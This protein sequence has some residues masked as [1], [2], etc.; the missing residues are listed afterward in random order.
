MDFMAK[1]LLKDTGNAQSLFSMSSSNADGKAGHQMFVKDPQILD[2][3]LDAVRVALTDEAKATLRWLHQFLL[4]SLTYNC[5]EVFHDS[6]HCTHCRTVDAPKQHTAAGQILVKAAYNERQ[7]RRAAAKAGKQRSKT[8]V[9]G[10][11]QGANTWTRPTRP[12]ITTGRGPKPDDVC[13][14]CKKTGHWRASCP[15]RQQN[16]SKHKKREEVRLAKLSRKGNDGKLSKGQ[17]RRVRRR[18]E[19]AA[20]TAERDAALAEAHSAEPESKRLRARRLS[21]NPYYPL[22][23]NN[24]NPSSKQ[25]AASNPSASKADKGWTKV[26][27]K[28]KSSNRTATKT[29]TKQTR[30]QIGMSKRTTSKSKSKS[31]S[32]TSNTT[33]SKAKAR[34]NPGGGL[35]RCLRRRL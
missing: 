23:S 4:Q 20:L 17:R 8:Q 25:P 31:R 22:S 7:A 15:K 35:L 19:I 13:G 6:Y 2:R 21:S 27:S 32:R 14:Y 9:F 26:Q 30:F 16:V 33:M 10:A 28:S 1:E 29:K 12:A 18:E 34:S 11:S 5:T 24:L 3:T